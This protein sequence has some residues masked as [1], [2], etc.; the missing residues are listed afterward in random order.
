[1]GT[2]SPVYPPKREQHTLRHPRYRIPSPASL[3]EGVPPVPP[4]E[5]S[6]PLQT[7]GAAS[8]DPAPPRLGGERWKDSSV[9]GSVRSHV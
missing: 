7:L 8:F 4:P 3:E 9:A 5:G 1:M 2:I 6:F